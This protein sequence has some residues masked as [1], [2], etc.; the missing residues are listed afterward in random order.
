MTQNFEI[1]NVKFQW[2][3]GKQNVTSQNNNNNNNNNKIQLELGNLKRSLEL[4]QSVWSSEFQDKYLKAYWI[5]ALATRQPIVYY[6]QTT[7]L[8]L[9]KINGDPP[10][11]SPS[12]HL[13]SP[14][15]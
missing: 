8:L 9:L 10:S 7:D 13:P 15:H 6:L 2:E 4:Q 3:L 11:P 5:S 14:T 12:S 1:E